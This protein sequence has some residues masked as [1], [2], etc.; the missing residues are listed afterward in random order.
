LAPNTIIIKTKPRITYP[1]TNPRIT[2]P[3]SPVNIQ[4][5]LTTFLDKQNLEILKFTDTLQQEQLTQPQWKDA[6]DIFQ[7]ILDSLSNCVKQTCMTQPTPPLPHRAK[8]QGGFLP[9]KQQKIWKSHLKLY[10][11]IRK[12]IHV[13]CHYHYTQLH[14]HPDIKTLFSLHNINIPPLP[15]NPTTHKQWIEDLAHI[16][17]TAKIDA[18]KITSKQTSINCKIAIKKYRALLNTKP[19]TIHKKI[20]QPSTESSMDCIKDPHDNILTNPTEIAKEIHR[21]Q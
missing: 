14:N 21:A 13:A 17:K 18:Y 3:I 9:R 11:S 2:Y 4:N 6:Q 7:K 19:K 5:L 15:T 10:H 20:F 16:G 8:I 12:A 1:N